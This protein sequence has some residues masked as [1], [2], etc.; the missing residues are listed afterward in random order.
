MK[1]ALG[2]LA[3]PVLILALCGAPAARAQEHPNVEHGFA[4][5]KACDLD[6]I[7]TFN[8]N[9]VLT[10]PLGPTYTVG[11]DLSYNL[12][13][14]YNSNP[15]KF[16]NRTAS[17]GQDV[18]L[19]VPVLLSNAGLGWSVSLGHFYAMTDMDNDTGTWAYVSS[20]GAW[21]SFYEKLHDSDPEDAGDVPGNLLTGQQVLYTRDGSYLR[22]Q[23]LGSGAEIDFPNGQAHTFD[24][25]GRLTQIRDPFNNQVRV[26]YSAAY[27]WV[28]KEFPAGAT[29]PQ[30]TQT[31]FFKPTGSADYPVLVSEVDVTAFGGTT[32]LYKFGY[33]DMTTVLRPFPNSDVIPV[34]GGR[35]NSVSVPFLTSLTVPDASTYQ[36]PLASSYNVEQ[37]DSTRNPPQLSGTMFSGSI[38]GVTLPTL[39]R[40]QWTYRQYAYP[41]DSSK[42]PMRSQSMGVGTRTL[43]DPSGAVLGTWTYDTQIT[44]TPPGNQELVNTVTD[45]QGNQVVRYFSVLARGSA[46]GWDVREYGLPLTHLAPPDAAGRSLSVQWFRGS[47]SG[48]TL[49]RSTYVRYENDQTGAPPSTVFSLDGTRLNRREASTST[50]YNDDPIPDPANGNNPAPAH[51]DTDRSDF[52]GLGHFRTE[53]LGGLFSGIS[54]STSFTGY[55]LAVLVPQSPVIPNPVG[56]ALR[57]AA[58]SP[59]RLDLV[60]QKI[61]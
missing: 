52:D 20:D 31:V 15:W 23:R 36:M 47:G 1:R 54:N 29:T 21:H 61:T 25:Q 32:A 11:G 59:W 45:P 34:P 17:N 2:S 26:D 49:V 48:R 35:A 24:A 13:L 3:L 7:N 4:A 6:S 50:V 22:L 43:L 10:I 42:F 27:T 39:G 18:T 51:S 19:A 40:V 46:T 56:P 57:P 8:G 16:R 12:S 14:V 53:A 30:R 55:N 9:L 38:L 5:N 58:G 60:R 28:I 44:P 41:T 37:P 33:S